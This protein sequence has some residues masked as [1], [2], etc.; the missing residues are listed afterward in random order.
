M[1]KYV[2]HTHFGS[3]RSQAFCRALQVLKL[4]GQPYLSATGLP[5]QTQVIDATEHQREYGLLFSEHIMP[6]VHQPIRVLTAAEH[7]EA[8]VSVLLAETV[9][10]IMVC[11]V[12]GPERIERDEVGW[13]INDVYGTA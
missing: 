2:A 11:R 3:E 5:F 4:C 9:K 13:L 6:S 7:P 8:I 12:D 10:V 1:D